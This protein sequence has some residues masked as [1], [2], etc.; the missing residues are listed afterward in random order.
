MR[1]ILAVLAALLILGS[2]AFAKETTPFRKWTY[3]KDKTEDGMEFVRVHANSES[4]EA[5]GGM[6]VYR[7]ADKCSEPVIVFIA[8]TK[9]KGQPTENLQGMIRVDEKPVH[10]FKYKVS[11][12]E[13]NGL[14]V[15]NTAEPENAQGLFDEMRQGANLRVKLSVHGADYIMRIPLAGYVEASAKQTEVCSALPASGKKPSQ[16]EGGKDKP[17]EK[18]GGFGTGF[19]VNN[20]G[21]LIT[22]FHVVNAGRKYQC[23]YQNNKYDAKL[24]KTDPVNDLA[25]LKVDFAPKTFLNFRGAKTVKPGE[26]VVAI[27]FPYY[28]MV[29]T[30]PNITTGNVSSAVG[31]GDDSRLLQTTAPV[32]PGNSGGPLLD[33]T[34]NVVGVV[35]SK[36]DAMAVLKATGDVPQN[37]NFA[38]RTPIVK[39]FLEINE[40]SFTTDDSAQDMKVV[41]IGEKSLPGV[42]LVVALPQ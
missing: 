24:I 34:G 31:L 42:V 33:S 35:V 17:K 3:L 28:G 14:A 2:S 41:E 8:T 26:E 13:N 6:L 16:A 10:Q 20:D 23:E 22:N 7:D 39:S 27:G 11:F 1:T 18:Q 25:L 4:Q 19:F 30:H 5:P 36:L 40:I 12:P 21:Y 15:V 32:Q 29:S 37:I 9:K 38:I